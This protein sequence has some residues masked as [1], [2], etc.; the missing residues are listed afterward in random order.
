MS[1]I[2]DP[3]EI[4]EEM[5]PPEKVGRLVT[6]KLTLN[7]VVA[8]SLA[9]SGVLS[10]K[11][12]DRVA[13]KVIRQYKRSFKAERQAGS[14]LAASIDAALN[15]R[16]LMVQRVQNAIV[17]EFVGEVRE[18]YYGEFYI[19]LPSS[20]GNPDPEHELHYGEKRRVG[21]GEMPGERPGCQ[22]GMELLI[23]GSELEL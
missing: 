9:K 19:W 23:K 17:R 2:F 1:V 18:Q 3:T 11:N 13:L 10:R 14:G 4:L 20:S 16:K 21:V 15:E 5:G 22:C 12:L 7:R 8:K 6:R